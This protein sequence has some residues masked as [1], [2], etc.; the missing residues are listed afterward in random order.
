MMISQHVTQD[1]EQKIQAGQRSIKGATI[2]H[3]A[4]H[5]DDILLGYFPYALRNLPGNTN[6]VLY[7]TSGANG[8]SDMYLTE[9][10][11]VSK[12]DIQSRDAEHTQELKYRL[13][14]LESEK[15]WLLCAGDAMTVKHLRAEFYEQV[16][17]AARL[18]SAMQ[19]DVQRIVDYLQIVQ[20]DIITMLVD[21]IDIGPSTHHRSQKVMTQA[22]AQWQALKNCS[23]QSGD[24]RTVTILG[25]RNI[26]SSFSLEQASMIIPVTPAELKQ[27]ESVFA[28]CFATQKN[29]FI[30]DPACLND[31]SGE[32]DMKNFAQQTTQIQKLQLQQLVAALPQSNQ[33][34]LNKMAG[35]IFLQELQS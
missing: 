18:A 14:E 3:T 28:H 6:H 29:K 13:R 26:W 34:Q 10:L 11:S 19:R 1:I 30:L 7:I 25:Y 23:S 33:S 9:H 16:D 17:N 4:P 35:A 5:H 12:Q 24:D 2:L 21:P 8:V 20:P 31:L 22:I 15:K 32:P 27:T